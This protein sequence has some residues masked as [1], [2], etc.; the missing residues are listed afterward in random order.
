MK[1]R[2]LPLALL[3]ALGV[4]VFCAFLVKAPKAPD[5]YFFLNDECDK[6]D[7]PQISTA[8]G[9]QSG[10]KVAVGNAILI[11]MFSR[12]MEQ[13]KELLDRHFSMAEE[14]DIPILVELDPITFWQDVPELWNWWDPTK[15]GY[16][17]K[18]KEN[19]EWTSWSSEDAVKVGWLNWGR[20][21][22]LLPMPN[23]FSPAYQ[24]AVKD[25]MDQ[26][27]TWTAD[28]YK[29]LPKSK[30]YLLGG[31]KITGELG[32]GVNNWYYPG[33]N[34]YYDKPEE[35]D[36][37]G[38]IRVD[39]MPSRGVGQIG[40]ASLK[41]SGIRSEGEITPADIYSLEKE[42][43]GFVADIA[44]GYGFPR[45]MLFSHSGGA[46]DDLAAAVQPN[47]CPTWSFYW[48][49]A[50]DPSLTPQVS[51]Y[52]KMSD[53]PYWG[54]SEWNIG[55]KPKEDWTEALRNCYSIPGCRFISLFNYGTIFSKDQD[56]NLVVNDAAVEALKEIQ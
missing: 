40:Y 35:E 4:S 56:G 36:P 31:V 6:F 34:S 42:Y 44:Q 49:E 38:G 29:S 52:L 48:A 47:S 37:K 53:A 28:W 1:S 16:D 43:A 33:G 5:H 20:Q 39:E 23:L 7:Y 51:K 54:C 25:R 50:A 26:F 17:P 12:P 21:I 19:V 55:D 32:F 15:P 9:P 2:V 8:F 27:M 45:G 22:R 46:G 14:Y 13:F 30:K 10:K 41:Y 18:N 24:A 3:L 11:Y